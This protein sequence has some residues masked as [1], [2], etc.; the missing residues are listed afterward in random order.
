[1]LE[2]LRTTIRK[3]APKAEEGI[4]Y[5]MPS[6]KQNGILVYFAGYTNHIGFYPTGSGISAFTNEIKHYKT[7][8][9]TIQFPLDKPIPKT[10]VTKIVKYRVHI[11]EEKKNKKTGVKSK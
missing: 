9:G 7:S 5:G 4:S 10:L 6:Y 11:N 8:K 2:E 1:L 3:A